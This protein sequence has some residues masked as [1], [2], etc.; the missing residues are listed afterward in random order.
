[1]QSLNHNEEVK[2]SQN[3][4]KNDDYPT[5]KLH[6]LLR[7]RGVWHALSYRL[8]RSR[9]KFE[10]H[11]AQPWEY[12]DTKNLK[13]GEMVQI[14]PMTQGNNKV[15]RAVDPV[16]KFTATKK[17]IRTRQASRISLFGAADFL[18]YVTGR[19]PFIIA[20]IQ[21]DGGSLWVILTVYVTK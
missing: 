7:L 10:E 6:I 19:M 13:P 5:F 8:K 15:F 2:S 9:R 14:D 21:V 1:M 18:H 11:H 20:S 17:R 4:F 16:T 12:D 3:S